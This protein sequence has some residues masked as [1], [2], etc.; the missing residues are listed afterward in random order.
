MAGCCQK[1][2]PNKTGDY[3]KGGEGFVEKID[4]DKSCSIELV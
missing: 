1:K 2:T 4:Q 3:I